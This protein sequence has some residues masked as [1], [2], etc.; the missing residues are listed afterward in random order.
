M[1]RG[2]KGNNIT[3]NFSGPMELLNLYE[4]LAAPLKKARKSF[5]E[6]MGRNAKIP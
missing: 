3:I 4:I 1:H 2:R 5:R 6:V